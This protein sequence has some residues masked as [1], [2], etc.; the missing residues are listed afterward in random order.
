MQRMMFDFEMK[1]FKTTQFGY[2][3]EY[4]VVT[5]FGITLTQ[6]LHC[7]FFGVGIHNNV[8][9]IHQFLGL[10]FVAFDS[11]S[12]DVFRFDDRCLFIR[13]KFVVRSRAFVVS[14]FE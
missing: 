1:L 4:V 3:L 12:Q 13:V 8:I 6:Y 2:A 7:L 11:A 5:H 14:D 9:G 10:F